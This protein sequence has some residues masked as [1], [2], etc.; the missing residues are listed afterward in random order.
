MDVKELRAEVLGGTT[1]DTQLKV[2]VLFY[3]AYGEH[4]AQL[5]RYTPIIEEVN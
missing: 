3:I 1:L 5:A 2:Q 4:T